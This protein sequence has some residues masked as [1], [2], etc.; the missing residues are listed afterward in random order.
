M[1][2]KQRTEDGPR[3]RSRRS[4][5]KS[6]F[7]TLVAAGAGVLGVKAYA[8]TDGARPEALFAAQNLT[9]GQQP[10]ISQFTTH[11]DFVFVKGMGAHDERDITRATTAVLD[12]IEEQLI[13]A[14]SSMDRALQVT[15]FLRNLRDYDAM[16]AAYRG[17]FGDNPPARSTVACYAGI[18]GGS[19]LEVDCI[20]AL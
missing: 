8:R 20:A 11:G 7:A 14:G 1:N 16:N 2:M 15:V 12:M 18:P 9:G 6:V 13:A 3:V 4:V 19:L 5:V 17:R 10:L